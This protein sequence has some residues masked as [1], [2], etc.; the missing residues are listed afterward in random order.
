MYACAIFFGL[1]LNL[2]NGNPSENVKEQRLIRPKSSLPTQASCNDYIPI[3]HQ[4]GAP[5]TEQLSTVVLN[6]GTG[7]CLPVPLLC[8]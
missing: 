4:H 7:G 2:C 6:L 1:G 8:Y 3:S 5:I